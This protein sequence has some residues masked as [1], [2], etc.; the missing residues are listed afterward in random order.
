[1]A[2]PRTGPTGHPSRHG[3]AVGFGNPQL[4]FDDG[5]QKMFLFAGQSK[6]QGTTSNSVYWEWD[7]VTAGWAIRDSGDIFDFGY[8]GIVV[9]AFDSLRRR[10]VMATNAKASDGSIKT[11]ELDTKGLTWYVRNLATGPTSVDAATMAYDS[12]RGVM[13]L[14]GSGPNDGSSQT[15]PGSTKLRVLRAARGARWPRRRT[16]PRDSAW[17]ACAAKPPL[18]RA[19]ASHARWLDTKAPV[20][21]RT[22]AP[23]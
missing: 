10:V 6:W 1:M 15:K 9:V 22:L 12:Q 13:V 17:T 23:K 14:F 3:Q 16:V 11:W 7:P 21:W 18:A 20:G 2:R 4:A 5:R 19:P 8:Y